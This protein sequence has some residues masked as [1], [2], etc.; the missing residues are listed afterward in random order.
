MLFF[1]ALYYARQANANAKRANDFAKAADARHRRADDNAKKAHAN[2]ELAG[3]DRDRAK[4]EETH[5]KDSETKAI[6]FAKQGLA[7]GMASDAW[8]YMDTDPDLSVN[9]ARK[10]TDLAQQAARNEHPDRRGVAVSEQVLRFA[11]RDSRVRSIMD[12]RHVGGVTVATYNRASTRRLVVTAGKDGNAWL[13]KASDGSPWA[14]E[15]LDSVHVPL[16]R[17]ADSKAAESA[18]AGRK[19]ADSPAD[20]MPINAAV[21][22]PYEDLDHTRIVLACGDP[23]KPA[24]PG[25]ALVWFPD[26]PEAR[27]KVALNNGGSIKHGPVLTAA[28]SPGGELVVTGGLDGTVRV[29]EALTGKLRATLTGGNTA[30]PVNAVAFHP[31]STEW[32]AVASGNQGADTNSANL[33]FNVP[34]AGAN[35]PGALLW[36]WESP[37]ESSQNVIPLS[38]QQ[39]AAAAIAFSLS[40]NH[41]ATAGTDCLVRVWDTTRAPAL[42]SDLPAPLLLRGHTGA[43]SSVAFSP[44]GALIVSAGRDQTARV[45]DSDTGFLVSTL[46]GHNAWIYRASFGGFGSHGPKGQFIVTA[47]FDGTSRVY[48]AR[49]G[50]L[51]ASLLGHREGVRFADFSPDAR[52]VVTA[53]D[54]GTARVWEVEPRPVSEFRGPDAQLSIAAFSH[55]GHFVISAGLDCQAWIWEA[56]ASGRGRQKPRAILAGHTGPLSDAGFSPDDELVATASFDGTA[57]VWE[58]RKEVTA[59]T[60]PR[61]LRNHNDQVTGVAFSPQKVDL[62]REGPTWLV[63]TAGRDGTLRVWN[64]R[65]G[66]E[67]HEDNPMGGYTTWLRSAVFSP[68]G[69]QIV[70]A[71]EGVRRF[72]FMP[73]CGAV[74]LEW[75]NDSGGEAR[76]RLSAIP[77]TRTSP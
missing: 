37:Q 8:G 21:F 65:T 52:T 62:P 2:A 29:W 54:D 77:N 68:D 61:I 9:L 40:G 76:R 30:G 10:A 38:S 55:D 14:F 75:A 20:P 50:V 35:G 27:R 15:K 42:S 58:W 18:K 45:W 25:E 47:S 67:L 66:V 73:A 72:K 19:P 60:G 34:A 4:T 26:A 3:K 17:A 69:R 64:S 74:F 44:D 49:T 5:A 23:D 33:K 51:Y 7:R 16:D 6:K 28:F 36:K 48:E 57:R 41:L 12:E 24:A 22:G 70:A 31:R 13:W 71:G 59:T 43:L 11:L 32:I 46:R 39:G 63:V 53:G 56:S 1:V